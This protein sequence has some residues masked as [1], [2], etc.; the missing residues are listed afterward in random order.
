MD[1][2]WGYVLDVHDGDTFTID[3][4]SA[5]S[6]NAFEYADVERVR[7]RSVSAPELHDPGGRAARDRLRRQICGKRVRVDIHC[8]GPYKRLIAEV[9]ANPTWGRR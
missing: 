1:Q 6:G 9:D 3:I 5:R 2:V 4:S 7:L 8:R